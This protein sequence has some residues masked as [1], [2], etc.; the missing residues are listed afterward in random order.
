MCGAPPLSVVPSVQLRLQPISC[1]HRPLEQVI[2][3]DTVG[4]GGGAGGEG[5]GAGGVGGGGLGGGRGGGEGQSQGHKM[6]WLKQWSIAS[7][8]HPVLESPGR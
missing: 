7:L 8:M 3:E 2:I 6:Y 1:G 4:E 5:G